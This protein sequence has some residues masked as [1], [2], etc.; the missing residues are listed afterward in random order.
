MRVLFKVVVVVVKTEPLYYLTKTN[1]TLFMH[2]MNIQCINRVHVFVG[3]FNLFCCSFGELSVKGALHFF[4]G[5][6]T[7]T[8]PNFFHMF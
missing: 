5:V 7:V 2:D 6:S 4:F 3:Q 1:C 8:C